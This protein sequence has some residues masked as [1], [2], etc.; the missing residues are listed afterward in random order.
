MEIMGKQKVTDIRVELG[1]RIPGVL[2]SC[3]ALHEQWNELEAFAREHGVT[4][5]MHGMF[6][7]I[8]VDAGHRGVAITVPASRSEALNIYTRETCGEPKQGLPFEPT[9]DEQFALAVAGQLH[10]VIEHHN[11]LVH[12]QERLHRE[13]QGRIEAELRDAQDELTREQSLE[14][15]LR[16]A[17]AAEALHVQLVGVPDAAHVEQMIARRAEEQAEGRAKLAAHERGMA[18]RAAADREAARERREQLEASLAART[19]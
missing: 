14:A 2:A 18:T 6:G 4:G 13:K 11:H 3:T 10:E 1:D 17:R 5:L 15:L 19:T 12:E 7:C 8:A 16:V 9:Q